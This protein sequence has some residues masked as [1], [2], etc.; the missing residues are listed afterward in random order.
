MLRCAITLVT[1]WLALPS[2][3]SASGRALE[4]ILG[5]LHD[6]RLRD[7]A[8]AEGADLRRGEG[9]WARADIR[10][11]IELHA[12]LPSA[13]ATTVWTAIGTGWTRWWRSRGATRCPILG[14]PH[15]RARASSRSVDGNDAQ[16]CAASDVAAYGRYA[17][18]VAEHTRGAINLFEIINEPDSSAMFRGTPEDYARMLAAAYDEIKA[19]SPGQRGARSAACR[20]RSPRIG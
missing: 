6:L 2:Q 4:S 15:R 7:A 8:R 20:A 1:L 5:A 16:K 9:A 17:G 13:I 3:A 10:L 18:E 11:D 12:G 14:D 19:R